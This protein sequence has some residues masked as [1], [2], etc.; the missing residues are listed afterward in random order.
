MDP[1]IH[2]RIESSPSSFINH[3]LQS[4][5]YG[6]GEETTQS[7]AWSP[8]FYDCSKHPRPAW[9]RLLPKDDQLQYNFARH[10]KWYANIVLVVLHSYLSQYG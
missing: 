10:A 9:N 8:P 5:D 1:G 2:S 4:L 7:R 3:T 6:S